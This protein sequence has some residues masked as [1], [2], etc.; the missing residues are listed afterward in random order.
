MSDGDTRGLL[1]MP[2]ARNLAVGKTCLTCHAE[3]KFLRKG[4]SITDEYGEKSP[5]VE[6]Y[7]CERCRARWTHYPEHNTWYPTKNEKKREGASP[8]RSRKKM[9]FG[10]SDLG[11]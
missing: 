10:D 2:P 3:M 7:E 9:M 8:A 4:K 6:Y 11:D 5:V 1:T